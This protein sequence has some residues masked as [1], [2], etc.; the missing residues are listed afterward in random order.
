MCIPSLADP[1]RMDTNMDL[2]PCWKQKQRRKFL[3]T[4][5]LRIPKHPS[6]FETSFDIPVRLRQITNT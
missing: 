6:Y 2:Y 1:F 5:L 3:H 4:Q